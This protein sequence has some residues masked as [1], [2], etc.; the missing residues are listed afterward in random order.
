MAKDKV[1][2]ADMGQ[3]PQ[4]VDGASAGKSS[5]KNTPEQPGEGIVVKKAKGGMVGSASR[6]ADG[7][8]QRGK[9]RGKTVSMCGG[10][11]V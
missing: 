1:Y 4:D 6:R 8:A 5:K 9:T 2:T 11:K 3:P 7:I 10:G